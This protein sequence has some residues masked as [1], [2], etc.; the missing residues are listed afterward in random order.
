MTHSDCGLC[1]ID[2]TDL[3]GEGL[4]HR[5]RIKQIERKNEKRKKQSQSRSTFNQALRRCTPSF[6]PSPASLASLK[7][8]NSSLNLPGEDSPAFVKKRLIEPDL[9]RYL[10]QEEE[11][12]DE[13]IAQRKQERK[14]EK[15]K[16]REKE[17]EER[18]KDRKTTIVSFRKEERKP[19]PKRD[20]WQISRDEDWATLGSPLFGD[21]DDDDVSNSGGS[22]VGDTEQRRQRSKERLERRRTTI[23]FREETK[24]K[25]YI[26]FCAPYLNGVYKTASAKKVHPLFPFPLLWDMKLNF[27]S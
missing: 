12:D 22:D 19:F 18:M 3:R 16:E 26:S 4:T 1:R 5:Y 23:S 7:F 15:R 10:R 8:S 17:R 13:R 25:P 9:A 11:A 20:K 27:P 6:S 21:G 14:E 2:I 24:F